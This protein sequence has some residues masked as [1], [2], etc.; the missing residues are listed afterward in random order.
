MS[1]RGPEPGRKISQGWNNPGGLPG[2]TRSNL[3]S[4]ARLV[5]IWKDPGGILDKGGSPRV[6]DKAEMFSS[7]FYFYL[8][9]ALCWNLILI[10]F[11]TF[12]F[13][14][15]CSQ[16]SV[17][18]DLLEILLNILQGH[19]AF[20]CRQWHIFTV[21]LMLAKPTRFLGGPDVYEVSTALPSVTSQRR[22]P[23]YL[24]QRGDR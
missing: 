18:S 12:F 8:L 19:F 22:V 14:F 23:H 24:E 2:G 5:D 21:S 15:C 3:N 16:P 1:S 7:I 11:R 20:T 10:S 13:L 4:L 6:K 17:S 9:N